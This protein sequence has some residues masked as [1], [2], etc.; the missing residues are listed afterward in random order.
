[1]NTNQTNQVIEN[2]LSRRSVRSYIDKNV[3]KENLE[4]LMNTGRYAPSGRN[5]QTWKFTAITNQ[6]LI[7][8]LYTV[9]GKVLEREKYNFYDVPALIIPSNERDSKF[10]PEDNA[11]ALQNIFLAGH[12]IGIG[13]YWINQLSGI[14]DNEEVRAVLDKL[15]IPSDHVVYGFAGL[16]YEASEPRGIINKK[17][18]NTNF[19]N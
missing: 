4:I 18:N 2:I 19:I 6:E 17:D 15:E 13:S 3:S 11:C 10:G 7:K 8:E 9:L 1:M 5:M 14:C 12:S 16:G